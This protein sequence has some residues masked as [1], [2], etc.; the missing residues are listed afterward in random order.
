MRQHINEEIQTVREEAAAGRLTWAQRNIDRLSCKYPA[1]KEVD[2]VLTRIGDDNGNVNDECPNAPVSDDN[3]QA[4]DGSES[5]V[6]DNAN[7]DDALSVTD[8]GE[9]DAEER[10]ASLPPAR[11]SLASGPPR[12]QGREEG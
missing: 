1:R 12:L 8:V 6:A 3:N 4:D 2:E 11:A 7:E 10:R 9:A 5:A